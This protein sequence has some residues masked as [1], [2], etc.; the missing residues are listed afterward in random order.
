MSLSDLL[1]DSESPVRAFLKGISPHLASLAGRTSTARATAASLG[2]TSLAKS[3]VLVAAPNGR[4]AATTGTA[5]DIRARIA[6]GGFDA[7]TSASFSGIARLPFLVGQI[8]NGQHRAAVLT[9]S[10]A[11]AE[12][13]LLDTEDETQLDLAAFLLAFCEQIF[14]GGAKALQGSLGEACDQASCAH[15]FANNIDRM[16]LADVRSLMNT[17]TPQIDAWKSQIAG[18]ER[19]EPNPDFSGSLLVDGADGDW[20]IGE[21]LI[22]CKVYGELSTHKLQNFLLQLLGYV[23]LDLDDSLKIRHVGLWLPRQQLTPIWSLEYLLAGDPEVILPRL[24][25]EFIKATNPTQVALHIPVTQRRKHQILAD[26]RHTHPEMLDALAHSDDNDIRFRVGRN[27]MSRESTLR[28]LAT[29]RYARARE[30][31]AMNE[32]VPPDVLQTLSRDSSLMVRRAAASNRRSPRQPANALDS[33]TRSSQS[34]ALAIIDQPVDTGNPHESVGGIVEINQNRGDWSLDTRWLTNFLYFADQ[35]DPDYPALLPVPESSRMWSRISRRPVQ[36]PHQLKD[37]FSDAVKADLFRVDRPDPVRRFVARRLNMTDIE[38]RNRLLNDEDAEIRW[39]TLQ[40]S[41]E[42]TDDSLSELLGFLAESR[43][44][45]LQF[46]KDRVG[47][48][49]WS[50]PPAVLDQEVLLLIA[51][52]LSTPPNA[53]RELI[54]NKSPEILLTLAS[55]SALGSQDQQDLVRKMIESRSHAARTLFASSMHTPQ[56]VLEALASDRKADVREI[57]AGNMHTPL[58]ALETLASDRMV[59]VREILAGSMRAPSQVLE[60]LVSDRLVNVREILAGNTHAPPQVLAALSTDG[61]RAVRSA[62]LRNPAT[63]MSIAA[64]I[65]QDSLANSGDHELLAILEALAHR[66][67]LEL[68]RIMIENALDELSKSRVRDPDMR[69]EVGSDRRA[70]ERTLIRLSKSADDGVRRVVAGNRSSPVSVLGLLATDLVSDV[71]ASVAANPA[72][73]ISTLIELALDE[74]AI[75]RIAAARHPNLKQEVLQA[76]LADHDPRVREAASQNPSANP[77]LILPNDIERHEKPRRSRRTHADFQEMALD[78]RAETRLAVAYNM[79]TPPDILRLLG[80]E[81]RSVRVRRAVAGNPNTSAEVLW[82]LATD[83]D[84]EVHQIVALNSGTPADLLVE[85]AGRSVDFALLVSLN[86]GAP[87]EVLDALA[88]DGEPLVRFVADITRA[89]RA[90]TTGAEILQLTATTENTD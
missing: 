5:L 36:F 20:L 31:V 68:P 63:P 53:L 87:N 12:E 66:L 75:V 74:D 65:A 2:L 56:Q 77:H 41:I 64:T 59:N 54:S 32:C 30:G 18:G 42:Q 55:N 78:K 83:N 9:E 43:D 17:G 26:N 21:T 14:R 73:A 37:G 72:T 29:D 3:P 44:A 52:H 40:R 38:V 84:L 27:K 81:R 79:D 70:G 16:M 82:S 89:N 7:R 10:F 71:R 13:L 50:T 33:G 67:D 61:N 80:G 88:A 24:R 51:S 47:H 76:L 15:E 28:L 25:G 90:L 69:C 8:E 35:P 19:F 85:L 4:D 45:R 39:S 62:V 57:L 34:D 86:P 23:M 6:M 60:A 49:S 48:S 46:R 1:K 11:L 22:D 58:R